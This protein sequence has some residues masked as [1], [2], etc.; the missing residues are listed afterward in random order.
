MKKEKMKEVN[1]RMPES[2]FRQMRELAAGH[3]GCSTAAVV[4]MALA[5]FIAAES[6]PVK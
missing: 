4:R 5:N 1:V 6:A 2:M 3:G